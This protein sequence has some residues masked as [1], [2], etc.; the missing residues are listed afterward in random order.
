MFTLVFSL[1][2][3]VS[4]EAAE[5][6]YGFD[7]STLE[8]KLSSPHMGVHPSQAVLEDPNNPFA[9]SPLWLDKWVIEDSGYPAVRFYG[10][11]TQLAVEPIG[12][13]QFYTAAAIDDCYRLS[14][15]PPDQLYYVWLLAIDAYQAQLD[16]FPDA[17]GYLADG[18]TSFPFSP[19]SFAA[20]EALG[21]AVEG[22]IK[23]E[24]EAGNVAILPMGG[25]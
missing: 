6:H 18:E 5:Y 3:C 20:I 10:W 14:C 17:L 25:E 23:V 19:L 1:L 2:G 24:D 22:W 9:N 21:G 16:H 12:E 7:I 15:V 4:P 13:N 11:A 8:L